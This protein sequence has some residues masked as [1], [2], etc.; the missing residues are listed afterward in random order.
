MRTATPAYTAGL[1]SGRERTHPGL[2]TRANSTESQEMMSTAMF[3]GG[4]ECASAGYRF[5]SGNPQDVLDFFD[6]F[7]EGLRFL[8]GPQ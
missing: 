1:A 7:I 3:Y 5:D 6:G 4:M 8:Q 2:R